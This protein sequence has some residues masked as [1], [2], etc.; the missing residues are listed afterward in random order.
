MPKEFRLE[1]KEVFVKRV[2]NAIMLIPVENRWD[3]LVASLDKFPSDFMTA[4]EQPAQ[5]QERENLLD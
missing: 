4:R 5:Q 1:G 2:G 3:S